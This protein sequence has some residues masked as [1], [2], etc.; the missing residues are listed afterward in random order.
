MNCSTSAPIDAAIHVPLRARPASAP[1][2]AEGHLVAF[3]S[4]K[5]TGKLKR[6]VLDSGT[7][8]TSLPHTISPPT[9]NAGKDGLKEALNPEPRRNLRQLA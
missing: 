7:R 3:E 1:A 9:F 5:A 6:S 4:F 8:A 2:G